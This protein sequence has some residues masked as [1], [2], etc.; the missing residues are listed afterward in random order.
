MGGVPSISIPPLNAAFLAAAV[1]RQLVGFHREAVWCQPGKVTR[2]SVNVKHALAFR[3]L[4]VVVMRRPCNLEARI[5]ARQFHDHE[6]PFFDQRLQVSI[7]SGDPNTG[8]RGAR[9]PKH[10]GRQERPVCPRYRTNNGS[11]LPGVSFHAQ[12]PERVHRA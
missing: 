4:K 12:L 5:L 11:T 6:L 2:A 10:F 9:R 1:Q 7:D 3:T 8:G